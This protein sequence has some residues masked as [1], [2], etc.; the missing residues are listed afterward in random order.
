ML[1]HIANILPGAR[2]MSDFSWSLIDPTSLPRRACRAA[3]LAKAR[4]PNGFRCTTCGHGKGWKSA[5]K[6]FTW[7]CASCGK[8]T[9]VPATTVLRG[10]KLDL[11]PWFCAD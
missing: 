5:T 3:H 11:T 8:R 7:E 2:L 4:W 6:A 1:E 10:S 9:S